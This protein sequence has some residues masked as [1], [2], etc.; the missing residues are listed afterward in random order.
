MYSLIFFGRSDRARATR[1]DIFWASVSV[2]LPL[3]TD[4]RSPGR[5]DAAG[6]AGKLCVDEMVE[7][8]VN[9][10][11]DALLASTTSS[12]R[13][14]SLLRPVGFLGTAGRFFVGVI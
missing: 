14:N 13:D 8:L 11:S 12:L 6:A 9:G 7:A 4:L 3:D 5:L 1:L 10:V 2:L